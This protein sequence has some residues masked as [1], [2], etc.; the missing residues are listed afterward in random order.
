MVLTDAV[1]ATLRIERLNRIVFDHL[2]QNPSFRGQY[3]FYGPTLNYDGLEWRKGRWYYSSDIVRRQKQR[4]QFP[5][6]PRP[7]PTPAPKLT[8]C[9]I[10]IP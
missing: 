5:R 4:R 2:E 9:R 8:S 1:Q 7:L 6:I 3:A 10:F